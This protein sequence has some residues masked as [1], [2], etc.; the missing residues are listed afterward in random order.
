MQAPQQPQKKKG[1]HGCVIALIIVAVLAVPVL[2][3]MAALGIYGT[4]KYLAAAK[5]SEAKN[6]IGA[7]MRGAVAAYERESGGET[8][9][10]DD[11]KGA[12][13][14]HQRCKTAR[15]VPHTVPK[16]VKYQ[17]STSDWATGSADT[18]WP[19]LRFSM[20]QPMYYQYSYETGAGT[21]K[22]GATAGGF[23]AS[24]R[25]DLNGDGVTSLFARG[26]DV[27]NGMVVVSTNIY[28]EN[29]FE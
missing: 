24:A 19:C 6:T 11:A 1:M 16:G 21:G 18:G 8:L 23:E 15:P 17:P 7:I 12:T 4:R 27:R 3:I 2:G 22:S 5:T 26:A 9:L 20:D 28:I 13:Y 29:E 10:A 14:T 25:G